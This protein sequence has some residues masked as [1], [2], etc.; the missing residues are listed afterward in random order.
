[1][2]VTS[3]RAVCRSL[4]LLLSPRLT[5]VIRNGAV[6]RRLIGI[7]TGEI[8]N[9]RRLGERK[10]GHVRRSAQGEKNKQR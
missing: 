6:E 7:A 1:M 5:G 8:K 3:S 2:A 4:G 9:A 10:G